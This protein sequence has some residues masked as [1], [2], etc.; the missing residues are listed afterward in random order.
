MK[1]RK[2]TTKII[3]HCAATKPS[4]D[5]GLAE[6]DRWHRSR[7]WLKVGYHY[8]IRRDGTVEKGRSHEVIGAHA[9][10][11]NA[12]SVGVCLVG[13][14]DDANKPEDNFTPEQWGA[15]EELVNLLVEEYPM[16]S[17][18]GHNEVD[19]NK[20]CPSFDVQ[21]WLRRE[22]FVQTTESDSKCPTCGQPIN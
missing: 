2:T 7:G 3:I 21:D 16:V 15:L 4:M 17:V 1:A 22:G 20:E 8:I 5:I 6:I 9:K 19:S 13:G 18:I 11:H 12:T 10:G 14:V